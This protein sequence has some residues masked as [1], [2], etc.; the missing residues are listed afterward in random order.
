M[1]KYDICTFGSIT[2]DHF[3]QPEEL[4]HI[5]NEHG[6][7]FVVE[8][9][10][11]IKFKTVTKMVGGG[12]AN[13]SVGFAKM[14][15]KTACFGCIGDDENGHLIAHRLVKKKVCIDFIQVKKKALSSSSIIFMLQNGRRT[16]FNETTVAPSYNGLDIND[17]NTQAIYLG[18]ISKS[19]TNLF[20]KIIKWKT[21]D[22]I[23]GWNPGKTQF[24]EGFDS[25][26][27]FF[28]IVDIL[29]LNYEEASLFT[30]IQSE[31]IWLENSG[32]LTLWKNSNI[33]KIYD[34]RKIAKKFIDAGI[35]N[36]IIT[37]GKNGAQAFSNEGEHIFAPL[38]D[39]DIKPLSTLGAGDSFSVGAVSAKIKNKSL[40]EM[41]L[42]GSLNSA[43]VIKIFGAQEGLLSEKEIL[44]Q[45]KNI[46]LKSKGA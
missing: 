13:S 14:G 25:F 28:P 45:T 4:Q 38:I 27:N 20:G 34:C 31:K 18:H 17:L 7:S 44:K 43:S 6:E 33:V 19:E 5:K 46:I 3:I 22:K 12:S 2:F 11:K 37:D 26:K 41:M 30:G 32:A 16:V 1:K 29:I 40:S 9:G 36:L 23:L 39:D 10:Q 21:D 24:Q 35:K 15:L 42:W 8:I